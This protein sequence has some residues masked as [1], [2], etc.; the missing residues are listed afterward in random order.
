MPCTW[1]AAQ[2]FA[3]RGFRFTHET[4]REWEERFAPLITAK[5]K[6]K[7]ANQFSEKWR[8]DETYVKINGKEHYLYRAV[9]GLGNLIDVRLS[10][11]RAMAAA[12][13]FFQQA[14]QTIKNKPKVVITDKHGSYP[15][16]IRTV[17][18]KRVD[19]RQSKYLNNRLEQD[20]RGITQRYRPMGGLKTCESAARFC[21]TFDELRNY[22]RFRQYAN[23]PVS[24]SQQRILFWKNFTWLRKEFTTTRCA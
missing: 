24:V 23:E 16:A 18:G 20:H 3:V 10:A 7:R 19:H 21:T 11:T 14:R 8:V 5:L 13:A 12:K 6:A 1:G 2:V 22:L 9:D 17:L 4:V 15:R